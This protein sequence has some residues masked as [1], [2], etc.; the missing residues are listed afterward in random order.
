MLVAVG[1]AA[2]TTQVFGALN[3]TG[4]F[5][6]LP[7]AMRQHLSVALAGAHRD[8]SV[9]VVPELV[10]TTA[11]TGEANG[12]ILAAHALAAARSNGVD[13]ILIERLVLSSKQPGGIAV[14]LQARRSQDGNGISWQLSR[15]STDLPPA[16]KLTRPAAQIAG[17][18][19]IGAGQ[20]F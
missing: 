6:D 1:F 2:D 17:S 3:W 14:R 9:L 10:L 12:L 7:S 19:D 4:T 5:A 18:L 16:Q 11:L 13:G 20:R 15:P 8:G